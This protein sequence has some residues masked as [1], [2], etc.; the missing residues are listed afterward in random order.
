MEYLL[1]VPFNFS[2]MHSSHLLISHSRKT[3]EEQPHM[4]ISIIHA[5]M[6]GTR[7]SA[8]KDTAEGA[9]LHLICLI[10]S[11][12]SEFGCAGHADEI[13]LVGFPAPWPRS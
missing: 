4:L 6:I 10:C 5:S 9:Y 13:D 8:G 2:S 7:A 3:E 1:A 11:V 12:V